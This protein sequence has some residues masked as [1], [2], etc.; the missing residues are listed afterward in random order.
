MFNLF[1]SP[2]F[3]CRVFNSSA[4]AGSQEL[5]RRHNIKI[6][7]S[8]SKE[9]IKKSKNYFLAVP[10]LMQDAAV[11]DV[12][13]SEVGA[14]AGALEMELFMSNLEHWRLEK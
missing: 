11:L 2:E 4:R 14:M 1:E 6:E 10:A 9:A 5:W 7:Q 12:G 3:L 13:K 8:A